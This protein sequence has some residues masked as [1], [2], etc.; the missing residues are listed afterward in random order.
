MPILKAKKKNTSLSEQPT[1]P[2]FFN[3]DNVVFSINFIIS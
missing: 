3:R 1:Q 2:S